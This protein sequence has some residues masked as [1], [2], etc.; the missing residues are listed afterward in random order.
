MPGTLWQYLS[1]PSPTYSDRPPNARSEVASTVTVRM[2][3]F[4]RLEHA[5]EEQG[6]CVDG[7][8]L[9]RLFDEMETYLLES[10]LTASPPSRADVDPSR[11]PRLLHSRPRCGRGKQEVAPPP[12]NRSSL[13]PPRRYQHSLWSGRVADVDVASLHVA[14]PPSPPSPLGQSAGSPTS[15]R[16]L[17]VRSS[18]SPDATLWGRLDEDTPTVLPLRIP[19]LAA[20]PPPAVVVALD[21]ASG[22]FHAAACARHTDEVSSSSD[23]GGGMRSGVP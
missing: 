1:R 12:R 9:E 17:A 7:P 14:C 4:H 3:G 18:P 8:V 21:D 13:H 2:P 22:K 23:V 20:P 15:L 6:H 19:P 11:S 16:D 5:P 10:R